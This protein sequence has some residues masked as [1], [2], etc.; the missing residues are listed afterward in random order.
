[1]LLTSPIPLPQI[2][3]KRMLNLLQT[4]PATI[5]NQKT[6]KNPPHQTVEKPYLLHVKENSVPPITSQ[7]SIINQRQKRSNGYPTILSNLLLPQPP[8]PVVLPKNTLQNLMRKSVIK[9]AKKWLRSKWPRMVLT[10]LID[11]CTM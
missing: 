2:L 9:F 4:L 8:L 7:H 5:T 6:P 11:Y 1:M 10:T 3:R